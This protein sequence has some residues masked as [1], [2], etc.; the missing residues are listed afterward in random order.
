MNG[1]TWARAVNNAIVVATY[2]CCVYPTGAPADT[3]TSRVGVYHF[4]HHLKQRGENY[5]FVNVYLY[6]FFFFRFYCC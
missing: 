4:H 1:V 3:V 2:C 6:N 5:R